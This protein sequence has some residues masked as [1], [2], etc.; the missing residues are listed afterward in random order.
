M[1][2]PRSLIRVVDN[3]GAKIVRCIKVLT[4]SKRPKLGDLAIV[5]LKKVKPR[6][7]HK[8][9]KAERV[10]KGEIRLALLI[11]IKNLKK[12]KDG[13]AF[14]LNKNYAI[15]VNKKG[16]ALGSRYNKPLPREL[17]SEKWIKVVSIAPCFF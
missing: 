5:S 10:K 11:Y 3:C 8:G 9:K 13:T 7:V 6:F 16:K 17:R 12:R 1:I 14:K 4:K 15:L 2:I